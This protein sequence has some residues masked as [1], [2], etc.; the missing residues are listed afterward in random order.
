MAR[1]MAYFL[2][3]SLLP[4]LLRPIHGQDPPD[5]IHC[6]ANRSIYPCQAYALY[7]PATGPLDLIP[8]L[9]LA[10]VGDL[11]D[12]SRL[13]IARASNLT[14]SSTLRQSQP[15][16]IPFSCSCSAVNGSRRAF[17]PVPYQIKSG[18]T[19][20]LVSIGPFG[21][22]TTW[23]AVVKANPTLVAT[24][25]SIGV[26]ATFPIFCQ[27]LNRTAA[28]AVTKGGQQPHALVTYALQPSDT[29]AS[30]AAS[31]STDAATLATLNGPE[32]GSNGTY[33]TIFVPL[34]ETPPPILL[35]N[36]SSALPSAPAPAPV[37]ASSPV[38]V[39]KRGGVIT[40]LA[41]GLGV[42]A[43]LWVLQLLLL[44][45][46][47]RRFLSRG[48]WRVGE[49]SGNGGLRKAEEVNEKSAASA[50][51]EK[52]LM[53]DLSELLD[54]YKVYR[55]EELREATCDFGKSSLIKGSVY[56]G[57]IDGEVFAI[58]KMKW[59]ARDELKI[60]Q[61]VNHTNLVKLEGFCI[62]ND[63]GTCYLVY[64]YLANGSLDSWLHDAP[65]AGGRQVLDWGT[66]VRVAL[67]LAN[68][69]Q[70]IH[71][72]TSPRVVHKDVKSSNV[73]LDY[74][75][76]AKVANFG[77]ART[78]CNAVTTHIVGTQGYIAPEYLADGVV[79]AKV[80]VFAYGVVLL[81]LVSGRPAIDA[82]GRALWTEAE[83]ALSGGGE[84]GEVERRLREWMDPVL[85]EQPAC[86]LESVMAV[87]ILARECLN[88]DPTKRPTMV[89]VTYKLSKTAD[90]LF[91][92]YSGDSSLFMDSPDSA[93]R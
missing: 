80:D 28:A 32:R 18:N 4:L 31:F 12:V 16:L 20:Y 85:V 59:N 75:F 21:N 44:A 60:L 53:N 17:H 69:L 39:K 62:D 68:G 77:L 89:E 51:D 36:T 65:P 26:I 52:L 67:D 48:R 74:R 47:W 30:V 91:S 38:V 92:D 5:G 63:S 41:I 24:N 88:R 15:L 7:R 11:F 35:S 83:E 55:I 93:A 37:A 13:S 34:Y 57:V 56:K 61:K 33:S 27:C 84:G 54:K 29:Y 9:D 2:F 87:T 71:E 81:E 42:V 8:S 86:P 40:G 66:R 46:V 25:L 43:A 45:W 82:L 50:E 76:R 72:H 10:S 64:E 19:F 78:G 73:L 22:L 3:F 14:T 6:A 1:L 70:Y 23:T 90:E 58:K 49:E 79:T